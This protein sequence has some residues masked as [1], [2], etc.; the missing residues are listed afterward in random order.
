M[1]EK[2]YALN[3]MFCLILQGGYAEDHY[4]FFTIGQLP[5]YQSSRELL[6]ETIQ[7][8]WQR[9]LQD[10]GLENSQI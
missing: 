3:L 10:S 8:C 5:S 9:L 2:I 6:I 7:Y 4:V 1:G